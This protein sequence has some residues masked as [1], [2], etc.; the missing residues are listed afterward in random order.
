MAIQSF[1]T[2]TVDTSAWQSVMFIGCE[3][4]INRETGD[5]L[6][7]RDGIPKWSVQVLVKAP[8]GWDPTRVANYGINVGINS[9]N[10]PAEGFSE[11]SQVA[12]LPALEVG[13]SPTGFNKKGDKA[14]GGQ[15]YYQAESVVPAGIPVGK[16]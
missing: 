8:D 1:S 6:V 9:V 10:D 7:S 5:A 12:F 16:S 11:G 4:K 3:R 15:F 14:V 2:L 13:T